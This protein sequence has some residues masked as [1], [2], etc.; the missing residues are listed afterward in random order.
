MKQTK[1]NQN[2]IV[3]LSFFTTFSLITYST[4]AQE[5]DIEKKPKYGIFSNVLTF[6]HLIST[7]MLFVWMLYQDNFE[8]KLMNV[9]MTYYF[10]LQLLILVLSVLINREDTSSNDSRHRLKLQMLIVF[11]MLDLAGYVLNLFMFHGASQDPETAK[12]MCG[13]GFGTVCSALY[14]V[15]TVA[16]VHESCKDEKITITIEDFS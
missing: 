15:T 11:V 7:S 16:I 13:S 3:F 10:S 12:F 9:A 2:F 4:K 14:L 5:M 6:I 1:K 8:E